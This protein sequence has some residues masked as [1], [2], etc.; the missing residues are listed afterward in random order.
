MDETPSL[1]LPYLAAG[2][3]QKHVTLNESL[4]RLDAL[5]QLSVMSRQRAGPLDILKEGERFLRPQR[6]A[7]L[8]RATRQGRALAGLRLGADPIP[9]WLARLDRGW[10]PTLLVFTAA[11]WVPAAGP[12][13]RD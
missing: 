9:R 13:Q 12:L 8:E 10:G 7:V 2:Q 5:V 1:A 4:R 11:G 6:G 3:A